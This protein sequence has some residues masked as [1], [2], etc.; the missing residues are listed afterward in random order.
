MRIIILSL[1]VVSLGLG[2]DAC[3]KT[4]SGCDALTLRLCDANADD[5]ADARGWIDSQGAGD[6]SARDEACTELLADSTALAAYIERFTTAMRP[7]P[8]APQSPRPASGSPP[9]TPPNTKPTTQDQIRT[10]GDNVE[11][12]GKA[13]EKAGEAI[14]KIEDAF[15]RK[16]DSN[17]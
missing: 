11:E 4:D 2:V 15:G 3:A 5:C 7:M 6:T 17:P 8:Q 1:S 14:D 12:I 13:G 16:A 9:Q 10:F